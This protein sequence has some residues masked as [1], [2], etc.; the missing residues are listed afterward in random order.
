MSIQIQNKRHFYVDEAG[1]LTLFDKRG[2]V[3]VGQEGVS[4][5]FMVGIALLPDPSLVHSTLEE[6]RIK[7]LV[8]PYFSKV[9]SMQPQARKTAVAFHANVDLPE[10]R[11]EV[12]ALLPTFGIKVWVA[13]RRKKE[14]VQLAQLSF[15]LTGRKFRENDFYDD[16]VKRLFRNLLHKADENVIYF[17]RRGKTTRDVALAAAIKK[18]KE[19]FEHKMGIKS[20]QPTQ[21]HSL[22]PSQN[23]GLQAIDYYLWALQRMYEKGE[24]RFF[25]LLA[26]DYRL[27]MDLDDTR[28][29]EYGEW[30]SDSN[31]L[32]IEKIMPDAS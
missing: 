8:D 4:K 7:L 13:I 20:N 17:S 24:D 15:E 12:F 30:Y 1:D 21:I 14:L 22:N 10:V 18:A 16:L 27:I 29:K 31:L 19:N 11:R 23:I 2:K 6:L 9:P 26:K 32:S 3:I 5:Y 25:H 28:N